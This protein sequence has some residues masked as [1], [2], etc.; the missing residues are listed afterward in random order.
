MFADSTHRYLDYGSFKAH[1]FFCMGG[2]CEV[3]VQTTNKEISEKVFS[4]VHKEARR[5]EKKYS[6]YDETNLV[7][8]INNAHGKSVKIDI[9]SFQ[10]LKFSDAL[11]HA[12]QGMFDITSGI[13]RKVWTFDG[14]ENVP[15][16]EE[17]KP[18]LTKIGWDKVSFDKSSLRIPDGYQLDFG[19]VGKEYAVDSCTEKAKLM[20][21]APALINLGG[22]VAVTGPKKDGSPW[23]IDIDQS[24]E[25][26]I[27]FEGGVATSGDK[28]RFLMHHGKRLSHILNPKTG[29]PVQDAPKS[30]TVFASNCTEAGA[31]STLAMLNGKKCENFLKSEADQFKII[32]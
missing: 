31:L 5:L 16:L 19:G 2:L 13:L 25:K 12:S 7:H 17:I 18:L 9:E 4:V 10:L 28:N 29:W 14:S 1:S 22:D 23:N 11:Y 30:V 26:V 24:D 15:E 32:R 21:L 27:L 20:K 3:L 8:K 6:R